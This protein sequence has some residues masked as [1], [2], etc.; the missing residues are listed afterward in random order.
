MKAFTYVPCLQSC[1]VI[2]YLE[3]ISIN[4][5]ILINFII[6]SSIDGV[7]DTLLSTNCLFSH[8]KHYNYSH[9]TGKQRLGEV[10]SVA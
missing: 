8:G 1:A 6:I 9:F 10:N 3:V 2:T 7:P 5:L 4:K